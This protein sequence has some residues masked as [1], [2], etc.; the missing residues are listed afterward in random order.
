LK[1]DV[2]RS[3]RPTSWNY[4]PRSDGEYIGGKDDLYELQRR[5]RLEA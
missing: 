5:S 3:G 2:L 4:V 1:E